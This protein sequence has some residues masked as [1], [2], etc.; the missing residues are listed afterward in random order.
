MRWW[1]WLWNI[2]PDVSATI[3]ELN[4]VSE[5]YEARE[6]VLAGR[7]RDKM[8]EARRL[9]MAA[10]HVS[11]SES[12]TMR[13]Q[14]L[15]CLKSKSQLEEQL[16]RTVAR[17]LAVEGQK[18]AIEDATLTVDTLESLRR[19]SYVLEA[20]GRMIDM[21]RVSSL[22]DKLETQMESAT[23]IGDAF[24]EHPPTMLSTVPEDGSLEEELN[25]LLEEEHVIIDTASLPGITVHPVP[26]VPNS[27]M[28]EELD[29]VTRPLLAG[30]SSGGAVPL[31]T[32]LHMSM[33]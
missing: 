9:G 16:N 20:H 31:S 15:M 29:P 13:R 1:Y 24:A 21:K 25:G 33:A 12:A 2:K 17:H 22:L 19:S 8:A 28:E 10:R 6:N 4:S 11:G 18:L 30:E 7:I 3:E 32:R 23:E 14:A 5:N 26:R 27:H